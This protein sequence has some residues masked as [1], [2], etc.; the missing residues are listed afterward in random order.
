MNGATNLVN[1]K[2]RKCL[3]CFLLTP[4]VNESNTN[5]KI[6]NYF[7][8]RYLFPTSCIDKFDGVPNCLATGFPISAGSNKAPCRTNSPCVTLSASYIQVPFYPLPPAVHYRN[9]H[10]SRQVRK[11]PHPPSTLEKGT[12]ELALLDNAG[13]PVSMNGID[14][15]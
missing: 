4:I 1:K 9:L 5:S 10:R 11:A 15:E 3:V 2:P 14:K 12:V 6:T 13:L 7:L 8:I